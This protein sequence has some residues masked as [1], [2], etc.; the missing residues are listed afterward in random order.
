MR[1]VPLLSSNS[2]C[3]GAPLARPS[4]P[5]SSSLLPAPCSLPK[6][7]REDIHHQATRFQQDDPVTEDRDLDAGP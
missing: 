4:L 6:H 2:T 5:A 3:P 1:P 7:P